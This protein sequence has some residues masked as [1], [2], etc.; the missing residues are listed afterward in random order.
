MIVHRL[1]KTLL[2]EDL[3]NID[4][5]VQLWKMLEANFMTRCCTRGILMRKVC[6]FLLVLMQTYI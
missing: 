1:P 2:I 5:M 4:G 3:Q 6:I